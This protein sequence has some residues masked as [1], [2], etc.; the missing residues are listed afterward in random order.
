MGKLRLTAFILMMFSFMTIY[1]ILAWGTILDPNNPAMNCDSPKTA[2]PMLC[3][4]RTFSGMNGGYSNIGSFVNQ[5]TAALAAPENYLLIAS[6][7]IMALLGGFGAMYIL[8][9]II[10]I[11]VVQALL[12]PINMMFPL[13][14]NAGDAGLPWIIGIPIIMLYNYILLMVVLQFMLGRN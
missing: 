12:F 10:L 3:V 7:M 9:A 2:I 4:W 6:G 8:P 5:I 11:A 14:M 13:A 1:F